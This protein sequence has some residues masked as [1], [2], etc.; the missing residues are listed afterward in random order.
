MII[1]D[2]DLDRCLGKQ[3]ILYLKDGEYL[4]RGSV[5]G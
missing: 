1:S 4:L 2:A 3:V 5:L